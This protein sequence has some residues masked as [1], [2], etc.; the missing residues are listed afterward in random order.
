[1]LGFA[2]KPDGAVDIIHGQEH[3]GLPHTSSTEEAPHILFK[4]ENEETLIWIR[5]TIVIRS[6][7][8]G[9]PSNGYTK[10]PGVA[11][12]HAFLY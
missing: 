8:C 6:D 7:R 1:V 4:D 5:L 3:F 10:S 2:E 11:V 9:V 12:A